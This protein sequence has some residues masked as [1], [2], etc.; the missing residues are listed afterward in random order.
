MQDLNNNIFST[1]EHIAPFNT[2]NT[3]SFLLPQLLLQH[4]N[5][6]KKQDI[7][8]LGGSLVALDNLDYP[9]GFYEID[10]N[11]K[12][13]NLFSQKQKKDTVLLSDS[14]AYKDI[15]DKNKVNFFQEFK[16][17]KHTF[18]TQHKNYAEQQS[19]AMQEI[20]K[21]WSFDTGK[22]TIKSLEQIATNILI[23]LIETNDKSIT[24]LF[25]N[26]EIFKRDTY[27]IFCSW[28]ETKGT[29]LFWEVEN[30]R[31]NKIDFDKGIFKGKNITFDINLKKILNKIKKK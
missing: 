22:V 29:F 11:K 15:Q 31:L 24:L 19:Y 21:K 6:V 28:T 3:V 2:I 20:I 7:V 4:F 18:N 1:A 12:S 25:A 10:N 14:L 17:L 9:R 26:L 8:I 5:K 13:F 16:F 27:N 23:K 30:K